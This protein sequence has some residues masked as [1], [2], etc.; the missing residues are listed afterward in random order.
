M[1]ELKRERI[2]DQYGQGSFTL[3]SHLL[4][5]VLVV[6]LL[7]ILSNRWRLTIATRNKQYNQININSTLNST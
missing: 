5:K 7:E 2:Y 3:L 4:L 1:C 6:E